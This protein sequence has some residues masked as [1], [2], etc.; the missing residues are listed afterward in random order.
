MLPAV[1]C[2]MLVCLE[3]RL[4]IKGG[5]MQVGKVLV[6]QLLLLAR[7]IVQRDGLQG[8]NGCRS[9][10]LLSVKTLQRWGCD[11]RRCVV[12]CAGS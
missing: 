4:T 1:A 11:A 8:R 7:V 9:I 5:A 6:R 2:R 3:V 10:L 12:L